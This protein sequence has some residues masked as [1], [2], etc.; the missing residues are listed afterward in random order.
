MDVTRILEADHRSVEDLFKRIEKAEG[1]DCQALI[2]ELAGALTAHMELEE[3]TLYPAM[4]SVTGSEAV[5]EG[6]T[7]H[8]LARRCLNDMLLL[9]PDAPGFG[10]ALD[11]VKA[12]VEHHVKDEEE[13]V[14]PQLRRDG[15]ATLA[16]VAT[17]FMSLRLELGLPMRAD[18]L[19]AAC[20]RDELVDEATR[21][22]VEV[23]SDMTKAEL[24]EALVN[25][26]V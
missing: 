10:A 23:T 4:K 8:Q 16:E 11:A 25:V 14:F 20:T 2:D 17:P 21:A 5:E 9:A 13:E 24:S 15:E 6:E 22:G 1:Q 18:A 3:R 12:G 19:A 26:M 7:E